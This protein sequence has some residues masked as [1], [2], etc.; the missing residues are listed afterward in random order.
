MIKLNG[1][2]ITPTLFPDNTSQIWKLP[3]EAIP[4]YTKTHLVEWE[5]DHEGEFMHLAQLKTLLDEYGYKADLKMTYLPYARQDKKIDNNNTF[6]LCTFA[7]LINTLHFEYVSALDVHSKIAEKLMTNFFSVYPE[8]YVEKVKKLT[9]P[10]LL[11]FPDIGAHYRY[12]NYGVPSI[13]ATKT[14]DQKTGQITEMQLTGNVKD[15]C[16]L[17]QD[18]ICDGG[19]TF[20]KLTKIL[21]EN[22]AKEVNLFV[23]HGIFS[24]GLKVLKNSG[25]NR[26]FTSKGEVFE[27][28]GYIVYKELA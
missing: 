15:K 3:P 8:E 28:Q 12:I 26:V 27:E 19:A 1:I 7:K 9:N 18:D 23:T 11:C 14:R 13:F 4:A 16:V 6:A 21:L 17:I 5:F 2:Q 10:D 25:I 20:T 22:G 24:K